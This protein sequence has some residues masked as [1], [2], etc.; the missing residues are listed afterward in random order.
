MSRAW[1]LVYVADPGKPG[2]R[3]LDKGND[4]EL[5]LSPM[6][7]GICRTD[8]RIGARVGDDLFFVAYGADRPLADRY[9][10]AA[11]FRVA[12]KIDWP[13]A[14]V[15]FGRRSN[16]IL[17]L[18]PS[19]LAISDRVVAYAATHRD[20]LRWDG[21]RR[22]VLGSLE[23]GGAWLR[24]R[25]DDFVTVLAGDEYIHA[26][27]DGHRDWRSRRIVG[28]YLVADTVTSKVLAK[29]FRY[30]ELAADCPQL[31]SVEK[32]RTPGRQPRHNRRLLMPA[33]AHYLQRRVASARGFRGPVD[34]H[35]R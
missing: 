32:L 12:E 29:P 25:A 6:T 19:G 20:E 13:E 26:Y 14:V 8:T 7:W 35:A 22:D 5:R 24:Q 17:E 9:Y 31:P 1:L 4:P 21:Q 15:R 18:L 2:E 28:P 27:Y 30:S 33:A 23:T 3:W 11:Q 34:P 16:V 10:L